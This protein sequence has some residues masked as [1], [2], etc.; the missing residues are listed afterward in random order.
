VASFAVPYSN[1][2]LLESVGVHSGG[3]FW[4]MTGFFIFGGFFFLEHYRLWWPP[5]AIELL[6]STKRWHGIQ[7]PWWTLRE[8]F[9]STS[10]QHQQMAL[11]KM[12]FKMTVKSPTFSILKIDIVLYINSTDYRVFNRIH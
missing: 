6:I 10:R 5:C 2:N 9:L 3:I 7:R 4:Q 11:V 12:E 8:V 1:S